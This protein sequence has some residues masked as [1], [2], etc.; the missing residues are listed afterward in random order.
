MIFYNFEAKGRQNH[1]QGGKQQYCVFSRAQK[2]PQSTKIEQL[3]SQLVQTL[4]KPTLKA[5][6]LARVIGK[7]ISIC[8]WT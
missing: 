3:R 8:H 7:L 5:K 6:E 2:L 4:D 1:P